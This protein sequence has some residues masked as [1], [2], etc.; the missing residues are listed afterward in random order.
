MN[1][2]LMKCLIIF[3]EVHALFEKFVESTSADRKA[4]SNKLAT[5]V[6][7]LSLNVKKMFNVEREHGTFLCC[8]VV[9]MVFFLCSY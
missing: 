8:C 2:N 7:K 5:F 6:L 4:K 1:M 9:S 3:F